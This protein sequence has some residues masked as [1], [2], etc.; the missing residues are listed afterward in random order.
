MQ[1]RAINWFTPPTAIAQGDAVWFELEGLRQDGYFPGIQ[2]APCRISQSGRVTQNGLDT[3]S[4]KGI[5]KL[6]RR[7]AE[8]VN[9]LAPEVVL[10]RSTG[11]HSDV[12]AAEIIRSAYHQ[13]A[14]PRVHAL[15]GQ[16]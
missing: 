14:A 7:Y 6:S 16:N 10:T 4:Q 5:Q 8:V 9:L 13:S 15:C 2:F 3:P 11:D 1:E 12:K